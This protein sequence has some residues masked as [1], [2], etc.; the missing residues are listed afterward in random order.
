MSVNQLLIIYLLK[1]APAWARLDRM[2]IRVIVLTIE[3]AE[4][5]SER[6]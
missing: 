3:K 1:T 4:Q 5:L 2:L 6:C